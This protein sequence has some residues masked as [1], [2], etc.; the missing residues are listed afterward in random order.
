MPARAWGLLI[1]AVLLVA[2]CAGTKGEA[3]HPARRG[4][5]HEQPKKHEPA[6]KP[7][8]ATGAQPA[9]NTGEVFTP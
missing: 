3:K 9:T 2:A 1:A 8:P 5:T 4:K 7:P 6:K